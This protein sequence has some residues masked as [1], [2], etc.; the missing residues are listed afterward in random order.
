M[1]KEQ[2]DKIFAAF[3]QADD[4]LTRKY[5]G[6]GLGLTIT[7][8]MVELMG[9]KISVSSEVGK[10]TTF[11]FSCVFQLAEGIPAPKTEPAAAQQKELAPTALT[12]TTAPT[13]TT[14]TTVP[15]A[16]TAPKTETPVAAGDENENAVLRGMRVLLVED[17]EINIMIAEELLSAVDIEVSSA[18]NGKEALARLAEA[19]HPFDLILMDLQM[20]VMDGYEATKLI[21]DKPEYRN[22][23]IFA[24]T[25]HA[26]DE[27][28]EHCLALGMKGHLSKPIDVETL[29]STLR[30]VAASRN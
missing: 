13:A 6:T 25:A 7:R 19:T 12:A 8:Q 22:I 11:S 23:P 26:F 5:G 4:S 30:Q 27:E 20:P 28:R 15:T 2:I 9:G 29:Y 18:Q 3:T 24:M 14:E 21:M 16:T 10:G 17:N 1:S